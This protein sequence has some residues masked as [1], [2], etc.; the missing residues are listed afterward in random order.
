MGLDA[1]SSGRLISCLHFSD[2]SA[3]IGGDMGRCR[4]GEAVELANLWKRETE[5]E[6]G[7]VGWSRH[8]LL[9]LGVLVFF[10]YYLPC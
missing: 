9:D 5:S 10:F 2:T 6:R 8:L 1:E 7:G 3:T 4:P